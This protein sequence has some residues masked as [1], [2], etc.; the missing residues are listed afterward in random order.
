MFVSVAERLIAGD[1]LYAEVFENKDPLAHYALALARLPTPLGAWLLHLAYLVLSCGA[2]FSICRRVGCNTQMAAV[3]GLVGSPIILTGVAFGAGNSHMVAIAICLWLVALRWDRHAILIGT[4]LA[5]LPFFKLVMMPSAIAIVLYDLITQRNGKKSILLF[6]AAWGLTTGAIVVVLL[7]RNEFFPY[8]EALLWNIRYS[9]ATAPVS[10]LAALQYHLTS[11]ITPPIAVVL[12]VG[13]A[14]GTVTWSIRRREARD[15][16]SREER[17]ILTLALL[18]A[19]TG[20]LVVG[21]T[22]LWPHHSMAFMVP[23]ILCF[24]AFVTTIYSQQRTI[25]TPAVAAIVLLAIALSGLPGLKAYFS[26]IEYA[27]ANI[28]SYLKIG[29]ETQLILDTGAP[30]TYARVGGGDDG[31]HAY[32]LRDWKLACRLFGQSPWESSDVLNSMLECLPKANVILVANDVDRATG[33]PAWDAYVQAV[34][35]LLARQY[36]C[37]ESEG[38]EICTK[39]G[40]HGDE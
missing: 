6:A 38:R 30:T 8:L 2:V 21:L 22:G 12:T 32:G 23:I 10:G 35:E 3:V 29:L 34:S 39:N 31:G 28:N 14:L 20:T 33:M 25:R 17:R 9:D 37:V 5:L 4:T 36:T 24:V 11:A 7:L 26:P 18:T 15:R 1:R 40:Y 27:R 16:G 19:I 13:A